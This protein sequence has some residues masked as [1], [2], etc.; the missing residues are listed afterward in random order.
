MILYCAA[1]LIWATRIK[2]TGDALG[3]GCRPVRSIDMLMARLA[4][5]DV[6]MLI[7][8]L[9]TGSLGID[10]IRTLRTSRPEGSP[11]IRIVAFGPHVNH[12]AL[13]SAT[14]AGADAVMTRGGFDQRLIEIL[15]SVAPS[16]PG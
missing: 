2:S 8:D 3:V 6:R 16:Q 9:E 5:C 12:E 7:V 1:D 13:R 15:T 4:D 10:M 11:P 14:A